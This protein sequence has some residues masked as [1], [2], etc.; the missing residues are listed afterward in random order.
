MCVWHLKDKDDAWRRDLISR[1][2]LLRRR[3]T[4]TNATA[5]RSNRRATD[6]ATMP[7]IVKVGRAGV[8]EP[9]SSS[10]VEGSTI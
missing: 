9:P 3:R 8:S 7:I 1:V 5:A 10:S 4:Q 2:R 6:P